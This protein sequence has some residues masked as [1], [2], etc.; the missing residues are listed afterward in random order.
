M[1]IANATAS[2]PL[3]QL[4]VGVFYFHNRAVHHTPME[5]AM[6][7]RDMMFAVNPIK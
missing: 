7:A 3:F 2:L 6:P 5:M 1:V 4:I